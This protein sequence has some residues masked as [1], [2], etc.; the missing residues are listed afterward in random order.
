MSWRPG[1][2]PWVWSQA[3]KSYTS[4]SLEGWETELEHAQGSTGPGEGMS[5]AINCQESGSRLG[6]AGKTRESGLEVRR[7]SRAS[8]Q[9]P[10]GSCGDKGLQ[11]I[12]PAPFL[13]LDK[14]PCP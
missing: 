1:S 3:N 11:D 7:P 12:C 10:R 9:E 14:W 4:G 6:A 5:G 2:K 8:W 13:A